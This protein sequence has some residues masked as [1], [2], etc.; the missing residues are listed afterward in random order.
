V[1]ETIKTILNRRSVRSYQPKQ[2]TDEE[3]NLILNAGTY[4]PSAM[5]E[6][7]SH[8]TVIQN[9]EV[10]SELVALAK[11]ATNQDRN[12]FYDAPTV[13]LVFAKK[14]N[15][16]PV[17]DA[18]L[19]IENIFLAAASLNIGS[20][21]VNCVNRIFKTEKGME[22]QKKIG[23]S[24]EYMSVGS[25]ILGYAAGASNEAAPR[26]EDFINIIK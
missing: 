7:S 1:N 16:A 11:K 5:N 6:Q 12:P 25:C 24:Q 2:I 19:A 18:S 22:L 3:L 26:K 21:W 4:A 14:D 17:Q 23:V 20:C 13:V 15:I 8:F 10:M 9:K